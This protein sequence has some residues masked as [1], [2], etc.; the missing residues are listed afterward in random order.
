[1]ISR[2]CLTAVGLVTPSQTVSVAEEVVEGVRIGFGFEQIKL[3][4]G[5][6]VRHAHEPENGARVIDWETGNFEFIGPGEA[7]VRRGFWIASV[8]VM[9]AGMAV[10]QSRSATEQARWKAEAARVT[11]V[12]DDWGIAHVHGKSDADAVFGMIYA[13]CED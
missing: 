3:A 2:R 13:Q 6:M 7:R 1:F 12:R 9:C 5:A 8:W 10:A 11:I 4:H